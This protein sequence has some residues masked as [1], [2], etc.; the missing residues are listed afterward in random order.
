MLSTGSK[1]RIQTFQSIK[2]LI[3]YKDNFPFIAVLGC[4]SYLA[5]LTFLVEQRAEQSAL[6]TILIIDGM[7]PLHQNDIMHNALSLWPQMKAQSL[8]EYFVIMEKQIPI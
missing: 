7:V 4:R 1:I 5:H 2:I 8:E 3:I 6:W